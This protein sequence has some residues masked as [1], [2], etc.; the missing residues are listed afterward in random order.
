L[1]DGKWYVEAIPDKKYTLTVQNDSTETVLVKTFLDNQFVGAWFCFKAGTK[2]QILG[3]HYDNYTMY[4][5]FVFAKPV[6]T[7]ESNTNTNTLNDLGHI[8]LEFYDVTV[9]TQKYNE[10]QCV[11]E[12]KKLYLPKNKEG[13][14]TGVTT[15][16]GETKKKV[17]S[18][19]DEKYQLKSYTPKE[20]ID[21]YYKARDGL[22]YGLIATEEQLGGAKNAI[23]SHKQ[24]L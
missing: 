16:P 17:T 3:F 18:F 14:E 6:V 23:T 10:P 11:A 22:I 2:F 12:E 13:F 5:E 20:T 19:S 7:N 1:H 8:L 21:I 4:K 15:K 24:K 9:Y